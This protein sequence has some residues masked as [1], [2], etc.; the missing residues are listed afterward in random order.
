[1]TAA[2]STG[3]AA[4]LHPH[5]MR[6][7]RSR[8][9]MPLT[10]DMAMTPG[11][12][13]YRHVATPQNTPGSEPVKQVAIKFAAQRGGPLINNAGTIHPVKQ[14]R[15]RV[16]RRHLTAAYRCPGAHYSAPNNSRGAKSSGKRVA[17]AGAI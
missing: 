4:L 3:A 14:G 13:G 10:Y 16:C 8:L 5:N 9:A 17:P 15:N 7:R 12:R 11:P 1:M 2:A 6:A